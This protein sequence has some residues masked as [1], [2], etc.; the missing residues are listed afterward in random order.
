MDNPRDLGRRICGD[1]EKVSALHATGRIPPAFPYGNA[2]FEE[3]FSGGDQTSKG[4]SL[5][6]FDQPDDRSEAAE[7]GLIPILTDLHPC[8]HFLSPMEVVCSC[9]LVGLFQAWQQDC[10][11]SSQV[12]KMVLESQLSRRNCQ[13]FS[14]GF[15]AGHF[16]GRGRRVIVSGTLSAADACQPA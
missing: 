4:T 13:M 16:G 8:A 3:P 9:F 2:S 14:T 7:T 1:I 11:M 10:T 6:L 15:N 12:S 5:A